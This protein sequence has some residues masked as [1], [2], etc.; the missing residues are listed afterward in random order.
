[1]RDVTNRFLSADPDLLLRE[2]LGLAALCAVIVAGLC[3]P[4]AV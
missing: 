4:V 1:M 3:L 2:A